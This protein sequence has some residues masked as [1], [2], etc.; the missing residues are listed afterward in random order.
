MALSSSRQPFFPQDRTPN[1]GSFPG[2]I[3]DFVIANRGFKVFGEWFKTRRKVPNQAHKIAKL[4]MGGPL[5][6]FAPEVRD[7]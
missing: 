3:Q 7:T 5:S 2:T 6:E 1:S 4:V